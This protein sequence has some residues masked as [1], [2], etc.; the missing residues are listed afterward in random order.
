MIEKLVAWIFCPGCL[1]LR[2]GP[3]HLSRKLAG[4]DCSHVW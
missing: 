2:V 4:I 1:C 3:G